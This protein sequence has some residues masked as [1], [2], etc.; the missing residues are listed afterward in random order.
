MMVLGEMIDVADLPDFPARAGSGPVPV[1]DDGGDSFE[2]HEKRLVR[3]ALARAEGN[4]SKAARELRLGAR[5]AALQ[6][7]EARP[8]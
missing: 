8:A 2:E 3:D 7:E 4:Q 1:V 5:C 6:D